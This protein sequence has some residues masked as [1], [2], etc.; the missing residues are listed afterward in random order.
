V[1]GAAVAAAVLVGALAVGD[2]VRWSLR[3]TAAARLGQTDSALVAPDRFF[4]SALA[5]D[6]VRP[7]LGQAPAA[8][9]LRLPGIAARQDAT[10]RI[11]HAEV[12][13]VDRAFWA[14]APSE[15][16]LP[17]DADAAAVSAQTAR[18]LAVKIGDTILVRVEKPG[19]LP[20]EAPLSGEA[21]RTV[22]LTLTV[23]AIAGDDQFGRFGLAANQVAPDNIFV[24]LA[25]LQRQLVKRP[26]A[27]IILLGSRG[28]A[29]MPAQTRLRMAWKPADAELTVRDLPGGWAEVR[30]DRIFI[31]APIGRAFAA[32]RPDALGVLTY[33][34]N[35]LRV[36]DRATPYSMVSGLGCLDPADADGGPVLGILPPGMAQDEIVINEWL[37]ED[38]GAKPG[39][40]LE[41][42]YFVPGE[43]GR[44]Q[45]R[46]GRLRIRAVVPM[47]GPA[48]DAGLVPDFPGLAGVK[49]C[50]DWTPGIPIDLKKIRDKDQA[51][52]DRYGPA[53]K[54]FVSLA[55]AQRMWSNRWGDLTALRLPDGAG[56]DRPEE[57]LTALPPSLDPASVG[58]VFRPIRQEAL[59]AAA[60]QAVD[61]GRLFLGLSIFLV[62][63][64]LILTGL[65]F[66]FGAQRRAEETGTLLALGFP[67]GRVRRL[68]LAEGGVLALTGGL[69]GTAAGLAYTRAMLWGLA[70]VWRGAV[71]GADLLFHVDWPTLGLGSAAGIIV[72]MGAI[73]LTV[74]RQGRLPAR[75]LLAAG[76]ETPLR[77]GPA[78][79]ARPWRGMALAAPTAGAA[80]AI[81]IALGRAKGE[82]GAGAFFGAGA[83]LL[84]AALG[85]CQTVLA[86]LARGSADRRLTAAGLALSNA[87]RRRGRSLATIA[88]IACGAFLVIAVGAFRRDAGQDAGLPSSG[89]GG[90]ALFGESSMPIYRSLT[91]AEGRGAYGLPAG[92]ADAIQVVQMRVH[93][94]DDASCLNLNQARRPRLA[95]VRPE[96]LASRGAFTFVGTE[97]GPAV[98]PPP[99]S[100]WLLLKGAAGDVVPAI[101][102]ENTITW[103]L[104]KS[105]GDEVPY[106]DERGRTFRLRLVGSL[107]GSILQGAL[108]ISEDEFIKRF[109]SEG[110]YRMFLINAPDARADEVSRVLS[111]RLADEG[112]AVMPAVE[113]L[114]QFNAVQ[115]TYLAIFQVLGGLALL[116]GSAGLGVVVMRNV[117][118]RR[119]E[120]ALMRAV[121]FRSRRLQRLVLAEH[122]ALVALGLAG[123]T[124]AAL[125]AVAPALRP[126]AGAVPYV[127]LGLTLAAV[128]LGGLVWT[129]L[130]TRLALR[131]PLLDAL[132]GE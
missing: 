11:N 2:S 50:R 41:M 113:R 84:V 5:A 107:A 110:G 75:E 102:D 37:R 1:L 21:D 54:A 18:R 103:S 8:A 64:S 112:L 77:I 85:L 114:A 88:L 126:T 60:G 34:V 51:Y 73:A 93:E 95:G 39:D 68:M 57:L 131:G 101:A 6:L 24:P 36:G 46:S 52:W 59:A 116:V 16:L 22:G 108:V 15:P 61:F 13:G 56:P 62:A 124:I 7:P 49:N 9:V 30:S 23:R 80:V 35:E 4:R 71:G 92:V 82:Q 90:F 28:A 53:P 105:V 78:R 118:E 32:V 42:T 97:G 17:D 132:R 99:A 83:L 44:L 130:A 20:P 27:N 129:Y 79:L 69:L 91:G 65:L 115:N 66:A 106:V 123:G 121:G 74:W 48:A 109:P 94:G 40:M 25:R 58:L 19:A 86:W 120:L 111:E 104:G 81:L 3:R 100:P 45:T 55:A 70:T 10:A 47:E 125:V 98:L 26:W 63:A 33:F 38:L 12:L 31:D 72:A 128:A 96:A 117:L 14:M 29:E 89:T 67:P 76:A 87:S 43:A 119:G 122:W 127:S